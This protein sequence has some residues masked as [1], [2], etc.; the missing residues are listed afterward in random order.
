ML[1]VEGPGRAL[2]GL[3]DELPDWVMSPD[4]T[5]RIPDTRPTVERPVE[6]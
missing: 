4:Q 1:L 3:V 5:Y 6:D 2:S